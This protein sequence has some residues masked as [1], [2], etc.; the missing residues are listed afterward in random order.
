MENRKTPGGKRTTPTG[1]RAGARGANA[2]GQEVEQAKLDAEAMELRAQ[3]LS[4]PK[5]AARLDIGVSTAHDRVKRALA[6][7]PLEA[8]ETYRAIQL[9][10]LE[11][12]RQAALRLLAE[13]HFVTKNG[14]VVYAR[15][16]RDGQT[17]EVPVRDRKFYVAALR[18]LRATEQTI[19]AL[20][21]TAAPVQVE[22]YFVREET[23]DAWIAQLEADLSAEGTGDP[24]GRPALEAPKAPGATPPPG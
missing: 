15:V 3:G 6:A 12:N 16:V 8:V 7:V 10:R 5:I 19:M 9:E 11:F 4:L 23:L 2:K 14:D 20:C 17:I 24:D 1:G 21:G 22:H 13:D 18:E